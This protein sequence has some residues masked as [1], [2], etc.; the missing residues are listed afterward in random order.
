V[1]SKPRQAPIASA[2]LS[3]GKILSLLP[4]EQAQ[5]AEPIFK[6]VL[7]G[8]AEGKDTIRATLKGGKELKLDLTLPAPVI[9]LLG[10]YFKLQQ[11]GA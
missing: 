10:G 6:K 7:G 11:R 3:V 1:D 2:S 4:P 5:R 9:Q 8:V